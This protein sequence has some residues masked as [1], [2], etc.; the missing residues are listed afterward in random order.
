MFDY[1]IELKQ[2]REDR[3]YTQQDIKEATG[4]AIPSISNIENKK[5]TPNI[6]TVV[7]YLEVIGLE[8]KVVNKK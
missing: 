4:F 7:K 8:L 1:G 6:E 5:Q 3:G 2:L